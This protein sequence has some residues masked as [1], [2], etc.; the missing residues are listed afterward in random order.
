MKR[1]LRLLAAAAVVPFALGGCAQHSGA[2]ASVNGTGISEA[3]VDA[4]TTQLAQLAQGD[5][6]NYRLGVVNAGIRGAVAERLAADNGISLSDAERAKAM[7][8]LP[9]FEPMKSTEDGT[10]FWNALA[11]NRV[12]T[13]ALGEDKLLSQ[14]AALNVQ[15]NPRYG[16]WIPQA[17]SLAG[18]SG[19]LSGMPPTAAPQP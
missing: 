10:V 2:A 8:D 18:D 12:V 1:P 3:Q 14:C 6:R 16:S 17:C 9:Q 11:N 7:A 4:A 15:V 19:S 5:P 13:L